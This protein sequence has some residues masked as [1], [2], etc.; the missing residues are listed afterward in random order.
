MSSSTHD[1]AALITE[2]DGRTVVHFYPDGIIQTTEIVFG[3]APTRKIQ[4]RGHDDYL[5]TEGFVSDDGRKLLNR[6]EIVQ[7]R[8]TRQAKRAQRLKV[9]ADALRKVNPYIIPDTI[10][11]LAAAVI[12]SLDNEG[13]TK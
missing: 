4:S 1:R 2:T 10:D 7:A 9:V 12:E 13:A 8:Q 3:D 11:A 6:A 5:F